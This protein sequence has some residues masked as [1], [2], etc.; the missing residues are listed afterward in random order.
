MRNV[1]VIALSAAFA[2]CGC[3]TTKPPP[4]SATACNLS[5]GSRLPGGPGCAAPGRVYTQDDLKG[6]GK[7]TVAGALDIL[8]P[9]ITIHH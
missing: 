7:T 9:S 3:A 2:L 5:T 4:A 1:T 6:T 8:D